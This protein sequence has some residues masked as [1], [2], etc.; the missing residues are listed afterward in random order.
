MGESFYYK[1]GNYKYYKKT[2][3]DTLEAWVWFLTM[4]KKNQMQWNMDK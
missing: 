3:V 4:K 1:D 2:G